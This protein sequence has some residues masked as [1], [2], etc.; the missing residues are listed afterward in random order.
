MQ[1]S[2]KKILLSVLCLILLAVGWRLIGSRNRSTR[3][4]SDRQRPVPVEVADILRGP[5]EE[6]RVFTGS[7]EASAVL[8]L[9]SKVSGRVAK[10]HADLS[11]PVQ[12][13]QIL[14]ELEPQQFEQDLARALAELAVAQAQ[15]TE[16]RNRLDIS[17]RER[18]RMQQLRERGISSVAAEDA[19]ESEFLI[20]SAAMAVAEAQLNAARAEVNSAELHLEETRIRARWFEGDDDRVLAAR[21]VEEGDTVSPGEPLL[22]IL[23]IQPLR[24]VIFVPEKDYGRL[25]VGQS[26]LLRTDAWPNREFPARISRISPV[27]REESRQARVEISTG[28]PDQDLKPGMFVRAQIVLDHL[29]DAVQ[30]PEAALTRRG[31][32][33][34]VFLVDPD[35]REA[36]WQ[37]VTPG[38]R[39]GARV[40][41]VHPEIEG[42]V[43]TLGQQLIDEGSTLLIPESA[44]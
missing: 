15:M 4:R 20:R 16:A 29:D 9:S 24:A 7:L 8:T 28:N 5:I 33:D 26:V 30:V 44:E 13:D 22:R 40:Q 36:H 38:I 17:K 35:T 32:V 41:I 39:D 27:F 6:K 23:E 11:D 37:V 3:E 10:V 31:N 14:V 42:R 43:V 34:G 21:S 18:E 12:R 2:L 1:S 25:S 19:A